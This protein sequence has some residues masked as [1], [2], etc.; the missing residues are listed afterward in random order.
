MNFF[1]AFRISLKLPLIMVLVTVSA[2]LAEG[3]S[4][5][6]ASQQTIRREA[7]AR[8]GAL[9]EMKA[10]AVARLFDGIDT[11]LRLTAADPSTAAALTDFAGAFAQLDDAQAELQRV[12]IDE[13]PNKAGEKDKMTSAGS[14][15]PY[16]QAHARFHPQFDRMQDAHGYYDMFLF[17]LEGNVVYTVFKEADFASN[18]MTGKWKDTELGDAFRA[19]LAMGPDDA[20][21]FTDFA[22][23]AP[24]AGAP[25][26]FIARPVFDEAGKKIGVLAYQMPIDAINALT[27]DI[28]G[29]GASGD[30][31]LVGSD[32]LLRTDSTETEVNDTL[33]TRVDNPVIEQA[34]AGETAIGEYTDQMGDPGM[35]FARPVDFLG[36]RWAMVTKEDSAEVFAPLE[37]LKRDATLQGLVIGAITLV[38]AFLVSRTITRPLTA[39]GEAMARIARKDFDTT[40]PET[41]RKDEIGEIAAALDKFRQSLA[42]AETVAIEAAFKG[43]GFEVSGAPMLLAD[44]DFNIIYK[45]S[46][47]D[48]MMRDRTDD[49]RTQ[50]PDFDPEALMGKNMDFFHVQ[51]KNARERLMRPEN[52]P[53]RMKIRIGD[54]YMGLLVDAVRDHEGTLIGYVL[55][56]RDQTYQM[57][58]QV[59]LDAID[60]SQCRLEMRL[61]GTVAKVNAAFC[62]AFAVEAKAVEG[63]PGHDMVKGA[64]NVTDTAAMWQG[65]TEGKPVFDTFR[66]HVGDKEILFQGSL[67][68]LPDHRGQTDGFLLL[69]V[70]V[71]EQQKIMAEAE[72]RQEAMAAAQAR[73]VETLRMHLDRLS[74]GDLT[75][76][77]ETRFDDEN[78]RIRV[79]F[80]K[81]MQSLLDAMREVVDNAGMIRNKA[82]EISAAS[83]NL[84]NRTESQAAT[85][86]ETAAALDQLTASV[87]SA[88][89]G[90]NEAA[91][92]VIEA[93]S[94]AE[95]SG[96][97]VRE[98]VSAMGEIEA[99]SRE[100]SKIIG[101]IDDIAF[102][103]NLLALNAGVEAAR[104]GDA[105]RG[106][107]VVASEVRA[108]AQRSSEAAREINTLITSSGEQVKRGVGL[109]GDAGESLKRIVESV[110]TISEHVGGIAQ[111]SEEQSTGLA[112]INAAMNQLDQVTQQNAAMV[113][114]TTATSHMLT[115]ESQALTNTIARFQ[116]GSGSARPVAKPER[117]RAAAASH[118]AVAP[119]APSE[120]E[121]WSE[122]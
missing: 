16:D 60:T 119:L 70:D 72:A 18:V 43:A 8:L 79:D 120:D 65:V 105:G 80:N 54:A 4:S 3:I 19:A 40:V 6:R 91:R 101:V 22:P 49:F 74:N 113:E 41:G 63:T 37:Q 67:S 111:S 62:E 118:V 96:N 106:F 61:D 14:G 109:V 27:G 115:D 24:S 52:L 45:N 112:E 51:P 69:G 9:G 98:A 114:E 95:Q 2:L 75:T 76:R 122:F 46:A 34:L 103:T 71:T 94:N 81:A 21:A 56:W 117:K 33:V 1:N 121:G 87:K 100:I 13:N 31:Y 36:T 59:V 32:N 17:D 38:L 85:L 92:I 26:S 39:V 20:S 88:A 44:T 83:D 47:I 116:L 78:D 58:T 55:E 12:Y 30:A 5:Y 57:H 108:L 23:Y 66:V 10:R 102:Q 28:F 99:S 35:W 15:T 110:G 104:A 48:R 107:A 29:L 50:I 7:D 42:A 86:E 77:I 11:D 73:V 84:S 89:A 68:P 53:H 93:R 97:V 64:Q 82:E 90:A 25:A